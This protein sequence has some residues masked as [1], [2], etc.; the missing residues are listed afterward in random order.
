MPAN[1]TT[2]QTTTA[3]SGH[4]AAKASSGGAGGHR[5]LRCLVISAWVHDHLETCRPPGGDFPQ[6]G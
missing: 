2:V 3:Y 1:A 6:H 4:R 5:V